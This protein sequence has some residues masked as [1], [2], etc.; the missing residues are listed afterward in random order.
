VNTEQLVNDISRDVAKA[1]HSGTSFV[2][3]RRAEQERN[4]YAAT[5]AADYADLARY[6]TTPEKLAILDEEFE[7]YR[8]GYRAKTLA[9]LHSRSRVMSWMITGPSRFPNERNRKR[10]ESADR[11]LN[12][13]LE[14]RKRALDAIE[15]TLRPELRPIMAGDDDAVERLEDKLAKAKKLQAL[16]KAANAAIRKHKKAGPDAQIAAL[17]VL[18]FSEGR[19]RDLLEPD[20]AGRIGVPAYELTNL[21]ANIKR[22]E[23]RVKTITVAQETPASEVEGEHARIEDSPAENRIRL[24]FPGKPSSEVRSKLKASGFRWSPTIGAWQAYRNYRSEAVAREVAG[25]LK[26]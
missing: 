25:V 9:H 23:G 10:N 20:F 26:N 6:A 17:V 5:L 24:Y 19:A 1:A 18:G 11:R 7:R 4:E 22:M 15:K 14:F 8:A 13:L 2:P 3:E 12:E 16:M 21:N